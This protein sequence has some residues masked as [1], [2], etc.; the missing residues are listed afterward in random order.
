MVKIELDI[1]GISF[2]VNTTWKTDAVPAVGDIV[3]VDKENTSPPDRAELR[4]TPSN[5]AFKWADE[6]DDAPV[7]EC[8]DYDNE[9]VVKKRTWKF[10]AEDEEMVCVLK[11]SFLY[12][13]E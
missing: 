1:N 7:L 5:Q 8:F 3:I 10:D 4:K 13:E 12:H 9:M 2:F 6:E 11:V